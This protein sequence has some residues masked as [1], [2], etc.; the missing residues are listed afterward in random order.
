MGLSVD[1]I[2]ARL[3]IRLPIRHRAALLDPLDPVHG[4]RLLLTAEG[5]EVSN[6][7]EINRDIL[8]LDWKEWPEH[9]IAFATNG[10][11]DYFAYDTRSEPYRVYYVGPTDSAPEA[12]AICEK[13][14]F[15]FDCFDDWYTYVLS[16]DA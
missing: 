10:C 2:E 9:L 8:A 15:L 6:I 14:G 5:N 16:Q 4:R 3:R 7:F 13:E 11:G 1:E 12:I